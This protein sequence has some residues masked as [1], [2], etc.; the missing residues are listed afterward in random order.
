M[1]PSWLAANGEHVTGGQDQVLHA[2]DLDLG[3]AVLRVDD[4][5]AD[6]DVDRD[7]LAVLEPAGADGDDL[8]LLRALLRGVGDDEPGGRH[9]LFL[10]GLDHDAVLQR[11]QLE[12][13]VC[14]SLLLDARR[15]SV[16]T[17]AVRVLTV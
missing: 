5:V 14:H 7:A 10:A 1:D 4:L 9:L 11:L 15:G 6:L 8:A 17:L 16:S 3:P 12:L 2:V 13:P